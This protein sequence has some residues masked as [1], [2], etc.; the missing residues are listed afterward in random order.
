MTLTINPQAIVSAGTDATIC[1]SSTYTLT[2]ATATDYTS[3]LWTSSGTGTFDDATILAATYTPSAADIAAGS[4][5]LTL[6][7]QS[8]GPCVEASDAM[9]LTISLQATADAGTDATICE[10]STYTLSTAVATNAATI[11]WSTSGTGSFSSTSV[12]NPVYT[13][14][15]ND[16]DDGSV[17]LTMTVTS[18]APCAGDIDQMTL[19][20]NP[21]AIVSAGTDATICESSTYTLSTA[22]ATDYT[23]LLWTSS[24]TGTFDDATL[25][26]ATYTPSAADIAAGSVTLTLTAQSAAPCVEASDDMVL[27]ISL[28]ATADAGVDATICEGSTY[29]LSTA[30]ATNATL[31]TW[32]SNGTGSFDN[33]NL[34]N[35]TY[36]PSNADILNGSVILTMTVTSAAPCA[37]DVDQMVLSIS[38]QSIVFAGFDVSIC[39]G[40]SFTPTTATASNAASLL[41]T[42]SGSGSFDDPTI[43]Y[44]VYTPSAAD[45]VAGSVVLTLTAPSTLPCIPAVDEMI[46]TISQQAFAY[47][48]SDATICEGSS[49]FI[50]DAVATNAA[51]ILWTTTGTGTFTNPTIEN[52][53]YVPSPNDIL[54]GFVTLT[55]IVNSSPPCGGDF[56]EMVLYIS[57]QANVYAGPDAS[58]CGAVPYTLNA[59]T[60]QF[61]TDLLW[62]SSGTGTFDDATI[63][64][65]VYTPSLADLA[66]GSVILTLTAQSASPCD[67]DADAMVLTI[68]QQATA[69]AGA[70][71]TICEGSNYLISDAVATNATSVVWTT[72]GTGIFNNPTLVNP[73]YVPSP[74][75]ILDGSVVLTMFANSASPCSGASDAMILNMSRQAYVNAGPNA[76][77]CEGSTYTLSGATEEFTTS[78]LWTSSGTGTFSDPSTL[79]PVYTPSAADIIAGSVTLTLT[80]QSDAPCTPVS[81]FMVLSISDQATAYAGEDATICEGST[82][83]IADAVATNAVSVLWI[84]SGTGVF[85]T[86]SDVNPIYVPSQSDI[87]NGSVTL[88]MYVNSASPCPGVNDEMVLTISRQADVF[89][90][91]DAVICEGS[92]YPLNQATQT[93]AVSLLWSTTGTG[94]FSDPTILNPVYTP[95]V[96]DI[97]S[98]SVVLTITAQSDAPCNETSDAMILNISRQAIANAGPDAAI[99]GSSTYPL[100]GASAL[101]YV[102][103]YWT[104]SGTGTF[105]SPYLVNPVYT[106]SENDILDG[107]VILT[108]T[109]YS[110]APCGNAADDMVLTISSPVLVDAGPD[111]VICEGSSYT[112][113]GAMQTNTVSLLWTTDGTGTF[114]DATL[115]NPVYT[116]SAADIAAGSVILTLTGQAAP[117]CAEV[118]DEMVLTISQD[119]IAFAGND[120]TICSGNSYTITDAVATNA[121][122]VMWTTTGTG[123]FNNPTIV[124]PTYTPSQNDILDG[125]VILRMVVNAEEPCGSDTDEMTLFISREAVVSAGTDHTIC[126]GST[127]SLA[128]A[129][130]SFAESVFWTT[131]G[132]GTFDDATSLNPVYTPGAAD[133]AAG[134]VTLTITATSALPC[135][136]ASDQMVLTISKQATVSAGE[137]A[138]ICSGSDYTLSG[139]TGTDYIS[140]TWATT[141]SGTFDDL[142]TLNPVYTPGIVDIANGQVILSVSV[143][144]AE[145]CSSVTDQMTLFIEGQPTADAGADMFVCQGESLQILG[146][147]ATN[148]SSLYWTYTGQGSMLG[149]NTLTPTYIPTALETGNIVVTLNVVGLEGCGSVVATDVMIITIRERVIA[150]AGSDQSIPYNSS[151]VLNGGASNGSGSYVYTWQPSSL[152]INFNATNPETTPLTNHTEFVLMVTDVVTG[153]QDLDSMMVF[154]DGMNHPPLAV[155]DYDTTKFNT[156]VR[157]NILG[158]DSDPEN[159]GLTVTFCGYPVNGL[160]VLNSDNTITYT[161]YEGFSGDDSLCYTICDKGIPVMCDNAMVYIHVLPKPSIDDI[162]I[163]NGVSPNKDGTNDT[164]I[165]KGIE[166]FPDNEVRIFNRWGDKIKDLSHYDNVNV[167][168]DG[169]NSNGELVTDGT[170]YYIVEIKGLQTFTGWIYVRSEN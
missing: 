103:V 88:T 10:G 108:M 140:V 137:D 29:T 50:S 122:S 71:N 84:T 121:V 141:G 168:W 59:A 9:V 132:T 120:F 165:I 27:T 49:Y 20:I 117:P 163:Y 107:Q 41:W 37:G 19:T 30:S 51:T 48:G 67:I 131:T 127:F 169:T 87:L 155:D 47:A 129:T 94:T 112:L 130:Q 95:S 52:P 159:S 18:A 45:I 161:P 170:Y 12:Q 152:L 156:S 144:S 69:Y 92:A 38:K 39:E 106:P 8:A 75:D 116:P 91:P 24:G 76:T 77:I 166:G 1:E 3:L 126:E 4:V 89:A 34:V 109:A 46:L 93:N 79:N 7:A 160:V 114:N 139:A 96:A 105:N 5:T 2:T 11:L 153:C 22:T 135:D 151:T 6:T 111:A 60:Q 146:A 162:V 53:V 43:L 40:E 97:A 147:T 138:T 83:T 42:S 119:A 72:S 26:A 158:N 149:I 14:S 56:D 78:L 73:V 63:L 86:P 102:S 58:I 70:D 15:Q 164:W 101:N 123:V 98:G 99:C 65:P 85:N 157:I 64:H 113:S 143:E 54:D 13:P 31:V 28:Q 148:Y 125:Q 16:I 150:D 124:N 68:S 133:I 110:N 145:G 57:R 118:S 23:S 134:S 17:I 33:V 44:P 136:P 61:A 21:Q 128:E 80:G 74:N 25:L 104:T 167:V 115:L 100:T 36:T 142:H 82:Y 66:S 62:T 154:I 35:A 81:D 32:S 90:G 55:M